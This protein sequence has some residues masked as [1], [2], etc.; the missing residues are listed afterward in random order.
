[1][2]NMV[3][4]DGAERSICRESIFGAC[5][6]YV[7]VQ[8]HY[9]GTGPAVEKRPYLHRERFWV[10]TPW[11]SGAFVERTTGNETITL[12]STYTAGCA[13]TETESF[14]WSLGASLGLEYSGLKASVEGS[15]TKTFETSF[16]VTEQEERSISKTLQGEANMRTCFVLWVL[17][18]Q[19]SFVDQNGNPMTDPNYEFDPGF[20]DEGGDAYYSFQSCGS[21][22]EI[23]K[24]IFDLATNELVSAEYIPVR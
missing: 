5:I 16:T 1:M 17:V 14:A 9:E 15:I 8:L 21:Q 22:Y 19:Y 24:Y 23:G 20:Y 11:E 13:K 3:E 7:H 10:A 12:T 4:W 18:E 2:P 6:S